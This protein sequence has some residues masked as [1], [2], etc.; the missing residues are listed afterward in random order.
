MYA[1]AALGTGAGRISQPQS[2]YS[3]GGGFYGGLI[4]SWSKG[5]MFGN[6][7]S[8]NLFASYNSGDEYTQGKQI[9]IV[10]TGNSKTAAYTV[11]STEIVVYKKGRVTLLDGSAKVTFDENYI[12]LLGD[13]PVVT[14]SPMGQCNGIYIESI[15]KNGF[16][17]KELNNGI[18]NVSV[19]WISVGDRV[20]AAEA[21]SIVLDQNFD[22]NINE[23]MFNENNLNESAKAVWSEGNKIQFGNLPENLKEKI[24]K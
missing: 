8:G 12:K 9:E 7:N 1:T 24:Q 20:D 19:S 22:S 23:V 21:S 2:Q 4:G 13:I 18:S 5:S 10:T 15:D 16:M 3:I 6:I 11:T 14:V 17:I